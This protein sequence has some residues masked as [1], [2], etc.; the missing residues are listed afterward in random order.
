MSR[1]IARKLCLIAANGE[2]ELHTNVSSITIHFRNVD[3]LS[4]PK[5]LSEIWVR[6]FFNECAKFGG[7]HSGH[8]VEPLIVRMSAGTGGPGILAKIIAARSGSAVVTRTCGIIF[9]TEG[10]ATKDGRFA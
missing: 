7:C 3:R 8:R 5:R 4:L 6:I 2:A 10:R 9:V 1:Q